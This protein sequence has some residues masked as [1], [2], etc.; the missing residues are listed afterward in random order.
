MPTTLP[1]LVLLAASILW[2]VTWWPLKQLNGLGIEGIPLTF[3][4][5]GALSCVLLPL[6]VLQRRQWRGE[7]RY[8][9]LIAA[10]G[11]YANLAFTS[12]MIY[13]DVVRVMVLFYLLP[14]WGVLGGRLFLGER[15]DRVRAAA[16]ALALFGAVLILG[17]VE[18]LNGGVAWPDLLAITCGLAFAGN[19]LVFRARQSLPIPSKVAAMLVGCFAL[20]IPLTALELQPWPQASLQS[21]LWVLAYGLGW[22]LLATVGTQWAVTHLEAG[23]ASILIILELLVAVATATLFGGERMSPPEMFGGSLILAAALI[24]AR[25]GTEAPLAQRVGVS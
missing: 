18:A 8:L 11:G 17:G 5:F 23:R 22:L 24:E 2:G 10:L 9:L 3:V 19:N 7:G 12:A 20:A 21:W 4:A 1:V 14:V 15:V 6:L 25:R 16:V 13:G